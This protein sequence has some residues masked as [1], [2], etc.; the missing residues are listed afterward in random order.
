MHSLPPLPSP[1]NTEIKASVKDIGDVTFS[2]MVQ[3]GKIGHQVK[4]KIESEEEND[5]LFYLFHF[6][7]QIFLA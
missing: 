6:W 5:F 4:V 2:V 1:E 3:K 7:F